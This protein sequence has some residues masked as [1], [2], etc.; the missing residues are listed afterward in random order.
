MAHGHSSNPSIP[1]AASSTPDLHSPSGS[2]IFTGAEIDTF[3][4]D[5]RMAAASIVGL[6]AGIFALGLIGYLGVAWWVG[7]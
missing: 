3:H 7:G 4:R 1:T 5:D 6:M 2:V